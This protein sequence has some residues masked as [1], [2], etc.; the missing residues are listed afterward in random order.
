MNIKYF[1]QGEG[2]GDEWSCSNKQ[3]WFEHSDSEV[4]GHTPAWTWLD[5][6]RLWIIKQLLNE[7]LMTLS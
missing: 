4:S 7:Q 3:R 6:T 5:V 1:T 2:G